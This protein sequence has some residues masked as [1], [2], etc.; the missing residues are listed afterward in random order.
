MR[1]DPG[2]HTGQAIGQSQRPGTGMALPTRKSAKRQT[3]MSALQ[4]QSTGPKEVFNRSVITGSWHHSTLE[5]WI[6]NSL[7]FAARDFRRNDLQASS[8]TRHEAIIEAFR[9][10]AVETRDERRDAAATLGA[11]CWR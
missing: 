5:S 8:D 4:R 9:R 2:F 11:R 6:R 7:P 1:C 3:R 10:G